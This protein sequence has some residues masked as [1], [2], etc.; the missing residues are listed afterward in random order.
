MA[1]RLRGMQLEQ[2]GRRPRNANPLGLWDIADVVELRRLVRGVFGDKGV[3]EADQHRPGWLK[4]GYFVD[5]PDDVPVG[6]ERRRVFPFQGSELADIRRQIL[7]WR[8]KS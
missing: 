8:A 4:C 3:I 7:A 5:P 6:T 2:L 1:R